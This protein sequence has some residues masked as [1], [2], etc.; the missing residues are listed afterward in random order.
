MRYQYLT[1]GVNTGGNWTTWNTPTGAFAS[2]YIDESITQGIVPM[3]V[4]Y[5]LRESNPAAGDESKDL[6]NLNTTATM[7]AWFA[8]FKL[9]MQKAGAYPNKLVVVNVEPDLW[10][11]IQQAGA[12]VPSAV[13]A[14]V[15]ACGGD[16][17]GYANNAAGFAQ[18][19]VHLRDLYAPNVALGFLASIWGTNWSLLTSTPIADDAKATSL[20][21]T[22]ANF[23]NALG[24]N[25]DLL[26]GE[27]SDRDSDF[28]RVNF[29][30]TD[31][32]Y[33]SDD[34]RRHRLFM[35]SLSATAN[36]RIVLW[37]I[38]F[39]NTRMRTCDNT[40]GHFQSNQVEWLLGDD[41]F[42]NLAAYR[43]AGVVALAFGGGATGVCFAANTN[44]DGVTNPAAFMNTFNGTGVANDVQAV[45]ATAG[46]API[47][48]AGAKTLTTPYAAD[49]D[50]G[51]FRFRGW[52]YY[53]VGALSIPTDG[54]TTG[55]G[56]G[57]SGGTGG[58]DATSSSSSGICG[59][60]G[61]A[62][63]LVLFACGFSGL[64]RRHQ[65]LRR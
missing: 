26:I 29:G 49:D 52:R 41:G 13:P 7:Q 5:T 60:G 9:L 31:R 39:G 48:N 16:V 24:A 1:G 27:F 51:Y 55:G 15:G 18:A 63:A 42:A 54:G 4:Y 62:A 45:P 12:N 3:F 11:Y 23:F 61:G 64:W 28:Y 56:S 44:N 53:Q 47:Y 20:G 65:P 36:R 25:F 19:I 30:Y 6:Q 32:W 57:G 38:P 37:Q 40:S 50:G 17:S 21:V 59:V 35:A 46:S 10:G 2:L 22:S 58:T 8:D 34:Y 14:K 43:D 33:D